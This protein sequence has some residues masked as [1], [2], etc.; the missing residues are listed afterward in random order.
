VANLINQD[1]YDP[2]Y[3]EELLFRSKTKYRIARWT[4]VIQSVERGMLFYSGDAGHFVHWDDPELA[5]LSIKI[6]LKDYAEILK[7]K[8]APNK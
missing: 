7:S 5:I 3:N 2:R 1:I 4:D 6:V 8:K